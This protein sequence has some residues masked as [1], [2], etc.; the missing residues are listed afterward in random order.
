MKQP[1]H[2]EAGMLGFA[3]ASALMER[4]VANGVLNDADQLTILLSARESLKALNTANA[5]MAVA[6]LNQAAG[7]RP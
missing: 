6:W 1:N 3:L 5:G 7:L 2:N 4:L